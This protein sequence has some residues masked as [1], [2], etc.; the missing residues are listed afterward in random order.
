MRP[1]IQHEPTTAAGRSPVGQR[2][3]ENDTRFYDRKGSFSGRS[4]TS[5]NS[6]RFYDSHGAYSGKAET[7]GGTTRYY[8]KTGR[9]VGRKT[10]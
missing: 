9:Y 6:T 5:G 8:D 1:K 4:T 10:K 7:S 3:Q 2:V